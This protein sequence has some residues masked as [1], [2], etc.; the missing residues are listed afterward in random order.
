MADVA[1]P[2]AAQATSTN[3]AAAPKEKQQIVKPD[4]PDEDKY[5]EE[6]AKLEKEHAAAQEKLVSTC[7]GVM[8]AVARG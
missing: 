2:P 1:T 8:R 7:P 4:K 6:L 3:G 5:K